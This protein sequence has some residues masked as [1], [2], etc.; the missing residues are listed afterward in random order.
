VV[1][2]ISDYRVDAQ[3]RIGDISK[4][5]GG[6]LISVDEKLTVRGITTDSRLADKD[7]LFF[8]I[9]GDRQDGHDFIKGVLENGAL[10]V[11]ENND[12]YKGIKVKDTVRALASLA[13]YHR[14]KHKVKIVAVTGSNGKTTTKNIVAS[15]LSEVGNTA[16]SGGSFN[17]HIGVPLTVLKIN[18]KLDYMVI[19]IGMNHLGEI[20]TL[21]SICNPDIGI[22]TNVGNVHLEFLKTIENVAK[23]KKELFDVL[24]KKSWAVVNLDD[25]N[26]WRNSKDIKCNKF[27]Y[28]TQEKKADLNVRKV[29]G[30]NRGFELE[31]SSRGKTFKAELPLHGEHNISNAA[32]GVAVAEVL[33]IDEEAIRRGLAAVPNE[34]KRFEIV[35]IN[36]ALDLVVD[37]YN[38]NPVSTEVALR[39]V[40]TMLGE[41]ILV[42]GDMLELGEK[43]KDFHE[44]IGQK[45][46][47]LGFKKMFLIGNYAASVRKG[48]LEKS[49]GESDIKIFSDHEDM[50]KEVL[51]FLS[52]SGD[53]GKKV[54]LIKGS[55]GMKMEKVSEKI[56][57]LGGA[58]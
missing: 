11:Y 44:L 36:S 28:S 9:K 33:N 41:K 46:S 10:P 32:A 49:T 35:K 1:E 48:A 2:M 3:M 14:T 54:V 53:S 34:S 18:E 43:S 39:N 56:L 19:E 16:K 25:E 23:A 57:S 45:A 31:F 26:V 8:A 21:A 20:S 12:D 47:A 7:D 51:T 13:L 4:A 17:N 22:I 15:I 58:K 52:D 27:T 24:D 38:A 42:F 50:S 55:R 29:R 6:D 5:I 30:S 37:C 40:S